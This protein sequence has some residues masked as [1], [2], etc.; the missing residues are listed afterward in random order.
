MAHATQGPWDGQQVFIFDDN[1]AEQDPINGY[2]YKDM[3]KVWLSSLDRS[4]DS[5][6]C[7]SRT[8]YITCSNSCMWNGLGN[9]LSIYPYENDDPEDKDTVGQTIFVFVA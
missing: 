1:Y 4:L 5:A 8:V 3:E 6:C 7:R 2:M 9:L